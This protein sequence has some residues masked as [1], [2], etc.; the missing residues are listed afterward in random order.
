MVIKNKQ[1]SKSYIE[2]NGLN[3]PWQSEVFSTN[4]LE[5]AIRYLSCYPLIVFDYLGVRQMHKKFG[6][7]GFCEWKLTPREAVCFITDLPKN[8]DFYVFEY[9]PAEGRKVQGHIELSS[10]M[11]LLCE[12]SYKDGI[13]L[14]EAMEYPEIVFK[15]NLLDKEIKYYENRYKGLKEIIDYICKYDLIDYTVEFSFFNNPLGVHKENVIFW[16]IRNF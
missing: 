15:T 7:C 10:N 11:D 12:L 13:I 16:E 4:K 9:I 8:V 14:R 5:K 3:R 1:D 2:D 6:G